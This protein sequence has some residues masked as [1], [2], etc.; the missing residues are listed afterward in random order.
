[1]ALDTFADNLRSEINSAITLRQQVTDLSAE[2]IKRLAGPDY[3]QDW[4]ASE[5]QQENYPHELVANTVPALYYSN[6]GIGFACS[7]LPPDHP[8]V[9]AQ[10][11]G[12]NEWSKGNRQL[13]RQMLQIAY[14]TCTDFGVAQVGLDKMPGYDTAGSNQDD[15]PIPLFPMV[16]RVSPTR[17]FTD[18]QATD[19]DLFRFRGHIWVRD[20]DDLLSSKNADGT[21]KFDREAVDGLA[22]DA[23][24]KG[25]TREIVGAAG[26]DFV[27]RNQ[28][29]G[30][31]IYVP[32]DGMIYTLAMQMGDT[33]GNHGFIRPPR[34]YFGPRSG[35]YV[36]FGLNIIPDQIYPVS[37]L[38]ISMGLIRELNAHAGQ[39]SSDAA[40]SK[41]LVIV[42]SNNKE[43]VEAVTTALSSSVIG[44]PNFDGK[45][46][47]MDVGGASPETLNH[48]E[49]LRTTLDRQSGLTE[50]KRGNLTGVTAREVAE[51][52]AGE[53]TRTKFIQ[54][55]FRAAVVD[56]IRIVSYLIWESPAVR[57]DV[58]YD[59]PATG[60]KVYQL[61]QGGNPGINGLP[62]L[63]FERLN[64][65]VTIDPYSMESVDQGVLQRR[66]QAALAQTMT[67][68]QAA[69]LYP[70]LKVREVLNDIYQ[71]VNIPE[72]ASRYVE[73]GILAVERLRARA[74]LGMDPNA[75]GG[76]QQPGGQPGESG[77]PGAASLEVG[78]P[79]PGMQPPGMSLSP[80]ASASAP[81]PTVRGS[82]NVR[83]EPTMAA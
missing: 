62:H 28:I 83:P 26:K 19:A 80:S 70:E 60:D 81:P 10:R 22:T 37:P 55:R 58:S 12:L 36:M 74:M 9:R 43:L 4:P 49:R 75:P 25:V 71:S 66:I 76:A 38:A 21:P 45:A 77:M 59:D 34:K 33:S 30:Y 15:G 64:A 48:I 3:R 7:A 17:F 47:N 1:M 69:R 79:P 53:D 29:V 35:P 78:G 54:S 39:A 42:D 65:S 5:D 41:R 46:L 6:P 57:F 27:N 8:F 23:N 51:A 32:E 63:P 44:V 18:P 73:M 11:I 24:T 40:S 50:T 56:A 52:S 14:D 72:G 61:F 82:P 20:K 13:E 2:F 31:E 16:R 68:L 67:V